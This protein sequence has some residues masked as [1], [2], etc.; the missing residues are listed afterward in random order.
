MRDLFLKEGS[1]PFVLFSVTHILTLVVIIAICVG[2]YL[3][4][5]RLRL[6]YTNRLVRY[7]LAATLL[8]SE[9]SL[10]W[11]LYY[12][13]DWSFRYSLPLHL[14]SLSLFLSSILLMTRSY[15]LFEFTY[16]VGLGSALQAMITPD[17]QAYTF[18]HFRYV[19][20]FISHGGIAIA[21]MFMVLVEGFRP[22]FHS[23][24][25]AFLYV[26][27]YTLF[28]F[29]VNVMIDGNYMYI[30][31]KPANPSIFDY[32]GPW[33][34]YIIPLEIIALVTFF[35]LYLPFY[36]LKKLREE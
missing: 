7:G 13:G 9:V 28:I 36:I 29:L 21:N 4:R 23:V 35:I 17:I 8:I 27:A 15:R 26:N 5:K 22:S 10:Q 19:H 3:F 2:M 1:E 24:F 30:M 14:S 25:R 32:L 18:P 34:F 33:P 12:I 20:F 31:R 6:G 11:W 16:F